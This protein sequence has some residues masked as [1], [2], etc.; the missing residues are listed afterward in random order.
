MVV[1]GV[2]MEHELPLQYNAHCIVP[3]TAAKRLAVFYT[4]L[5]KRTGLFNTTA[6]VFPGLLVLGW[7]FL[8]QKPGRVGR[9]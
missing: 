6:A 3:L 2:K 1:T 4:E 9:I 5:F 7:V 8:Y